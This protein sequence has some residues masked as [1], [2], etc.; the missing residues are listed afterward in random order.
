MDVRP[1]HANSA[2]TRPF[3]RPG[4]ACGLGLVLVLAACAP[5]EREV[6]TLKQYGVS[7]LEGVIT[8]TGVDFDAAESA[9]GNGSLRI[10]AT[11]PTTVRLFETGDVDVEDAVLT[12]AAK[13]RTEGVAGGVYLEMWAVFPGEGE[14]FSRALAQPI[15]GTTGWTSQQTPFF[16]KRGQNPGNLKLNLVIEGTGTVWI[17]QIEVTSAS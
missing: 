14:F 2:E 7:S 10:A 5:R 9:D 1:R 3:A 4:L 8:R 13:I 17:D 6:S 12:Y 11:E 15:T 16:L